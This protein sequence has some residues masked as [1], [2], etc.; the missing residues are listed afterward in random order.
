MMI[1]P[2]DV[3]IHILAE[4]FQPF[5]LHTASGRTFEVRH[6]E[7][8]TV[9]RNTMMVYAPPENA[10]EGPE[11]WERLSYMLIESI[12]PLNASVATSSR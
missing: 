12:S 3:L 2:R 8:V 6:P 11:R 4:P 7:F 9:G 5:R 10:P 1:P